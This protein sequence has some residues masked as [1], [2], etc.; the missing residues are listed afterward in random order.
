MQLQFLNALRYIFTCWYVFSD[1]V[2]SAEE[3]KRLYLFPVYGEMQPKGRGNSKPASRGDAY[4]S[5]EEQVYS[6]IRLMCRKR[7]IT[8]LYAASD[9]PLA[10]TER[11]C[12]EKL[13]EK[14]SEDGIDVRVAQSVGANSFDTDVLEYISGRKS[15]ILS[16]WIITF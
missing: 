1:T 12:L 14:L 5:T 4:G 11:N 3:M 16:C 2:K 6:R 8:K 7:E 13:S 10:E 9:F 15:W